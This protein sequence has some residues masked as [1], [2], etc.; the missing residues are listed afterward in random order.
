MNWPTGLKETAIRRKW[1][2]KISRL[3]TDQDL[4]KC[5]RL[6]REPYGAVRRWGVLFGYDFSDR[7]RTVAAEQWENVDWKLRDAEIARELGVTRECVR[8]VRRAR[9]IGPSAAQAAT[10]QLSRFIGGNREKLHGLLVEEVIHHSSTDLP[11]HVVRRILREHDVK[12]HEATSPLRDI[13]WRLPNR[14][15]ATLWNTS[16]RYIANLRARLGVGPAMWTARTGESRSPA[17]YQTAF[18]AE[19]QKATASRRRRQRSGI[20][21]TA[22]A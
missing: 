22:I 21:Q 12:P 6:L 14:D 3:P 17:R 11:Y 16:P 7:R 5:V 20:R 15:L 13:D 9:G 8:L 1:F 4:Q 10:R 2:E 18:T 19:R